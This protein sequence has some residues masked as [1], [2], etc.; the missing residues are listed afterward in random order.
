MTLLIYI[1]TNTENPQKEYTII[2]RCGRQQQKKQNHWTPLKH[3]VY[4]LLFNF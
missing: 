3:T 2:S 1:F 4:E